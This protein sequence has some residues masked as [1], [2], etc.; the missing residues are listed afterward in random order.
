MEKLKPCP[1]CGKTEY[2]EFCT[3]YVD[4]LRGEPPSIACNNCRLEMHGDILVP[5]H[6][7]DYFGKELSPEE[8]NK[9]DRRTKQFSEHELVRMW[10]T[11]P[12]EEKK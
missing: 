11:R 1:F 9:L 4:R 5:G 12:L 2:L 6:S 7:S 3:A 8:M 10:N